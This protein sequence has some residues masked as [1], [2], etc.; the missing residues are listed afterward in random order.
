MKW[1][2]YKKVRNKIQTGDLFF[3]ASPAFFSKLIRFFT[4]SD[5]SHVGMFVVL[6][7]NVFTIE[8]LEGKGCIMA[9][10]SNRL[11][12][13]P[14]VWVKPKSLKAQKAKERGLNDVW[15]VEYDLWGAIMSP[16]VDTKSAR[17]FCSEAVARWYGIIIKGSRS[18]ITPKD[19]LTYFNREII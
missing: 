11:K 12:K 4:H 5:V 15:S 14:F 9:R 19:L 18:G 2:I 13:T 1:S 16:F 6:E 17:R 7:D 3:T 10:A 8:C